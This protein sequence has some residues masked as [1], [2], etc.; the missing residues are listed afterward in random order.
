VLSSD[1]LISTRQPNKLPLPLP[2]PARLT[3][4]AAA[5]EP[6]PTIT[7]CPF[8]LVKATNHSIGPSVHI[9]NKS[10]QHKEHSIHLLLSQKK[11][12]LRNSE[13]H[14]ISES[15][16]P[17]STGY[18]DIVEPGVASVSPPLFFRYLETFA[19]RLRFRLLSIN[20]ITTS[21]TESLTLFL[22]LPPISLAS[23][24]T[25]LVLFLLLLLP[26]LATLAILDSANSRS[27]SIRTPLTRNPVPLTPSLPFISP[28]HSQRYWTLII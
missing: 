4:Q 24:I 18:R 11:K 22:F 19:A 27:A 14:K 5:S 23:N 20:Q 15:S 16:L 2:L 3:V 13:A 1:R 26:L 12:T 8:K 9:S 7:R 21:Q 10:R 17:G 25:H 28:T 6:S